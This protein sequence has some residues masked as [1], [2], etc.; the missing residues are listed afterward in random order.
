MSKQ[1]KEGQK[2]LKARY[3]GGNGSRVKF[4]IQMF[5]KG[6]PKIEK[7]GRIVDFTDPLKIIELDKDGKEGKT[8]MVSCQYVIEYL[9]QP[10]Y[11][12][13]PE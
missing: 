4:Y 7:V 8:F 11:L 13:L 2:V 12:P 9:D 5:D 3:L 1:V 6:V 10:K